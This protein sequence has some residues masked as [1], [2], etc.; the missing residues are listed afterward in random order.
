[1][2]FARL[3]RTV[4]EIFIRPRLQSLDSGVGGFSTTF[5]SVILGTIDH[6]TFAP[7]TG[8]MARYSAFLGCTVDVHYRAGDVCLPA[9][10]TFVADSGRSIFLEQRFDQRG[11]QKTFRWEVPYQYIVRIEQCPSELVPASFPGVAPSEPR[12]SEDAA[13]ETV[14]AKV[15]AAAAGAGGASA[16]PFS[17]TRMA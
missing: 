7:E 17:H 9:S 8:G 14:E 4:G 2:I 1:M 5:L 16:L 15:S 12:H 3:S 13:R 11:T 10:G 6:G